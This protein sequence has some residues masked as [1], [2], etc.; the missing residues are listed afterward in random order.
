M[1]KLYFVTHNSKKI[2][3]FSQLFIDSGIELVE[4]GYEICELQTEDMDVIIKD[5]TLKAFDYLR[6]PVLVDHSGLSLDALGGLPRGLTQLFWDKLQGRICNITHALG[7]SKA[8]ALTSLGYCDGKMIH[9]IHR[10]LNGTIAENY[11]HGYRNFQWDN[12]FIP[13]GH[14][15][16]FSEMDIDEKN[17]FSQRANAVKELLKI[18][19]VR[20]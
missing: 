3:E 19:R 6:H 12:I 9:T 8:N 13:D 18:V 17:L 15:R 14:D 20:F 1:N 10:Q 4:L 2:E 16:V 5:K 7:N 11:R